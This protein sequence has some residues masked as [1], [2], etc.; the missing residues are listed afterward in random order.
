[1]L[2]SILATLIFFLTL[3]GTLE[4]VFLTFGA[5]IP[6][7]K[8]VNAD[9]I[10]ASGKFVVVVPAHNEELNLLTTLNSLKECIDPCYDTEVVVIADNCTDQTATIAREL[11][12]RVIERND[13]MNR[14]KGSALKFAFSKLIK[15]GYQFLAVIDADTRVE[16]NFVEVVRQ[17]FGNGADAVQVPYIV[18]NEKDNLRTRLMSLAFGAFNWLRPLSRQR[19]GLS[20]GILGNGFVLRSETLARA[21]YEACSIVEDL[22]YHLLLVKEKLKVQFASGTSVSGLIPLKEQ[23]L[24]SQR[25][26]WEGG[27][28]RMIREK[29]PVLFK[30]VVTGQYRFIEPLL[31][32]LLLPLGYMGVLFLLGFV[33]STGILKIY[34]LG[35]LFLLLVHMLLGWKISNGSWQ[36]LGGVFYIP[37]YLFWKLLKIVKIGKSSNKHQKWKRTERDSKELQ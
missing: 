23:G 7:R 26:R 9:V 1:M 12:I 32:L 5:L 22:E 16:K 17:T 27:R 2:F 10:T 25:V 19:F 30:A 13:S 11:G 4:L 37:V 29:T 8:Q 15:E 6:A 28:L 3:P 20:T 24:E 21:P 33:L 36:Q 31:E 14:G 18:L 35:T 34:F